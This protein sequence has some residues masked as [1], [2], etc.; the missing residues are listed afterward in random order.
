MVLWNAFTV[1]TGLDLRSTVKAF[2]DSEM[3]LSLTAFFSGW[4]YVWSLRLT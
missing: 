2:T 3:T 1:T 4:S